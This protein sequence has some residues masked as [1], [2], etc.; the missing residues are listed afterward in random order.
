MGHQ[1]PWHVKQN[2]PQ[3]KIPLY[4]PSVPPLLF[5]NLLYKTSM[6]FGSNDPLTQNLSFVRS[7]VE[8]TRQHT[9][10]YNI[11]VRN[12]KLDAQTIST[13]T[14]MG[15]I[16][17]LH[18][19]QSHY[20]TTTVAFLVT[21]TR[22]GNLRHRTIFHTIIANKAGPPT[23]KD[24]MTVAPIALLSARTRSSTIA[25]SRDFKS[26]FHQILL[27]P[28]VAEYYV[29]ANENESGTSKYKLC[30]AAMGHKT[31][32]G[33]ATCITKAVVLLALHES[34]TTG[35]VKYDIIIDDVLFMATD[36]DDINRCLSSFDRLCQ[37]LRISTGSSQEPSSV[38]VHRG[39]EFNLLTKTQKLKE[40]FT[41]KWKTRH[42]IYTGS[43]SIQ[44]LQSLIGMVCYA[45]QVIRIK[46][47]TTTF[48]DANRAL[49]ENKTDGHEFDEAAIEVSQNTPATMQSA[50]D[51]PYGGA[52]CSDATPTRLAAMYADQ[53]GNVTTTTEDLAEAQIIH[54]AEA[55]ASILATTL[56]RRFDITHAV[57]VHSDNMSWLHA[58]DRPGRTTTNDLDTARQQFH[59]AMAQLNAIPIFFY[60]PSDKNPMDAPSRDKN[61]K[62]QV[63]TPY[64]LNDTRPISGK[65]QEA[66]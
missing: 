43:H 7:F 12:S 31:S 11:H 39:I 22:K 47:L 38:I 49:L 36:L 16:E 60:I 17:K 48:R 65:R 13:L 27:S 19:S 23:P 62:P 20:N 55:K 45:A 33:V 63:D 51:T 28:L 10:L 57:H 53:F 3:T 35:K 52:I 50:N 29:F 61:W 54:T 15:L 41:E 56:I 58:V 46:S 2:I 6:T 25:A 34:A 59:D 30:R 9:R 37:E 26:Y 44:K 40:E 14:N 18:D 24:L 4:A 1:N 5:D 21:E 66:V 42:E 64:E 8:D 32:P